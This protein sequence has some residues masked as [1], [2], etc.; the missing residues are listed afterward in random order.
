MQ[1]QSV[2]F[3]VYII[4]LNNIVISGVLKCGSDALIQTKLCFGVVNQSDAFS[5]RVC[6][7]REW[8]KR[9]RR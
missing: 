8:G 3:D 6:V 7:L 5:E 4:K 1:I 2:E 9:V